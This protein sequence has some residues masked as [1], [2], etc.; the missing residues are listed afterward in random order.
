MCIFLCL[1]QTELFFALCCKELTKG[2]FDGFFL[3]CNDLVWNCLIII[4]ET[5]I[6]Q[7]NK[8]TFKSG[9]CIVTE[10]SGDL[11]GTIRTEVEENN[12]IIFFYNRNRFASFIRDNRRKY[13]LICHTVCIRSFHCFHCIRCL[14]TGSGY[15]GIICLLDT[16]PV[17]ITI[18]CIITTGNGCNLTY[19]NFL[20]FCFQLFNI[21]F[22]GSRRCITAVQK[23][24]YIYVCQTMFFCHLK[25]TVQMCDMAVYTTIR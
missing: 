23:C 22:S 1:C 19:T 18:H 9:K 21:I 5:Y 17:I 24:V 10:C 3:K 6:G 20:H 12:G 14:Y 8:R 2:I 16:I 7:R 11:T 25:Q 13:K 4:F 15:Q